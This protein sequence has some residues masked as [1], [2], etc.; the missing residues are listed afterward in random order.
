[1]RGMQLGKEEV[2]VPLFAADMIIYMRPS[3]I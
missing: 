1:M 2:K 3:K